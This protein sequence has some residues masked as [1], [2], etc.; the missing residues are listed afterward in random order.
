MC[1]YEQYIY[2]YS[3]GFKSLKKTQTN[4]N[5][6]T[7]TF[8]RMREK[9][10]RMAPSTREADNDQGSPICH[11]STVAGRLWG[12]VGVPRLTWGYIHTYPTAGFYTPHSLAAQ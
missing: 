6:Q 5:K 7:T 10:A 11:F 9:P 3:K 1:I 12:Y 2:N 4:K 8:L